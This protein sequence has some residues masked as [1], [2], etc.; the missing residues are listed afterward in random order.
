MFFLVNQN[1]SSATWSIWDRSYVAP[2]GDYGKQISV[3]GQHYSL[4]ENDLQ[5]IF[6]TNSHYFSHIEPV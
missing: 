5:N 2:P 6:T 1:A 3:Q 4:C